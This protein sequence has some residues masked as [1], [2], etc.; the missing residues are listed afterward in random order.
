MV[1]SFV[2]INTEP[3]AR[4]EVLRSLKRRSAVKEARP[5]V[6]MHDI[7]A[8]IETDTPE[9]AGAMLSRELA[10]HHRVRLAEMTAIY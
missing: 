10:G 9:E 7:I 5:M 2:L 1:L 6:G 8:K 4:E 3:G